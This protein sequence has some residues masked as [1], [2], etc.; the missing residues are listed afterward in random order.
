MLPLGRQ[1]WAE[2]VPTYPTG[3]SFLGPEA[4]ARRT[5]HF[6]CS[7]PFLSASGWE[8]GSWWLAA[9]FP[10]VLLSFAL[11]Q[12]GLSDSLSRACPMPSQ[13]LLLTH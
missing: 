7:A 1:L 11:V 6:H 8:T 2:P 10:V 3:H 12:V 5:Q 9:D 4:R 13:N